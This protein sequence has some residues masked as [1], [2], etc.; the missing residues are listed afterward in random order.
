[1]E[2]PAVPGSL[3]VAVTYTALPR[4]RKDSFAAKLISIR[5]IS[6]RNS[7]HAILARRAIVM[8]ELPAFYALFTALICTLY[9][10]EHGIEK[11]D[12]RA[13]GRSQIHALLLSLMRT[14]E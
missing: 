5:S 1:M 12:G 10:N 8:I 2:V 13:A 9:G 4:S 14:I 6:F 7:G 11:S 3:A